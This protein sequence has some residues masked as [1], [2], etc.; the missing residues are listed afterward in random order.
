ML[1]A[2]VIES[3]TDWDMYLPYVMLA[4]RSSVNASTGC[5]PHLMV[6]GRECNM[7]IDIMF[8]KVP[9]DIPRC[10]QDYV[11]FL[12]HALTA[13]H[14]FA[15]EHL[16]Q[17]ALRQKRN[18]DK[19]ATDTANY[20]I[21]DLVRYYYP[22][23]RQKSKFARPWTG[24]W[25][26]VELTS[27]VDYRIELVSNTKKRRVV[28]HDSLKPFEGTGRFT[29]SDSSSDSLD[30][31]LSS[32]KGFLLENNNVLDNKNVLDDKN[33]CQDD[34][35]DL[36][37][38]RGSELSDLPASIKNV[39]SEELSSDSDDDSPPPKPRRTRPQRVRRRPQRYSP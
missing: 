24:P 8:D 23:L 5:S 7:P 36:F 31:P 14:T 32:D 4:Y 30:T 9:A 2:F 13:S 37:V 29:D 1:S 12:R 10:P 39:P 20:K 15:R 35:G 33:N 22:P 6:Y 17:A 34:I 18:Y 3:G 28:H 26:I 16:R 19:K 21:G 38:P 27:T 11:D 25:R